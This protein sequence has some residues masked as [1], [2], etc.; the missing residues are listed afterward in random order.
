GDD[1]ANGRLEFEGLAEI[2]V[3][4]FPEIAAV[5][6]RQ[7][8][9]EAERV[10]KFG[11]LAGGGAFAKHLLDRVTRNNMDQKK[12][13]SEHQPE[14][15]NRKQEAVEEM[16]RHFVANSALLSS[17]PVFGGNER[18]IGLRD[19]GGRIAFG[20]VQTLNLD[21][22]DTA[23]V[24]F[25]DSETIA[26]EFEAFASPRNEAQLV[27]DES[28]DG[29]VSGI[30]R[31]R[32]V[33]LRIEVADIQCGVEDDRAIGEGKRA[34]DDVEFIVDFADELLE[35][36]FHGD[37]A[38]DA[39]ELVDHNG[40][41]DVAVAQFLEQFARGLGFGDHEDFAKDAAKIKRRR[42][43]KLFFEATLGI[44]QDPDHVLDVYKAEDM[45]F[46]ATVDGDAR[47]LRGGEGFHYFI[48]RGFDREKV[49]I[50]A[51]N[52]DLANLQV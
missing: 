12:N 36:I 14:G 15:G 40:N 42:R 10:A 7:G 41:A 23:A 5:L 50:W 24:H 1:A 30:F 27:E 28:A 37:E 44:E 4:H 3:G 18:R 38:K 17:G 32:N 49:H 13:E 25:N 35:Q 9:I 8:T 39:A 26:T 46:V 16:A 52:H 11:D 19:I 33:V 31:E 43:R 45:V 51:R 48:Q 29:G 2:P 34:L 47:A 6:H 20:G 21:A 22:S